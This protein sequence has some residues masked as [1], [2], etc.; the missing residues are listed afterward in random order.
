MK[1]Y[2]IRRVLLL[3]VTLFAII[4]INFVILNLAPGDP[5]AAAQVSVTGEAT[6][7]ADSAAV[8]GENQY[9][10]FREH[11]GLTLPLILNRWPFIKAIEV[12]KGLEKLTLAK[13]DMGVHAYH[14]LRTL[15]G[16]RARFVLPHLIQEAENKSNSFEIRKNAANLFIRGG[17][18]QGDVGVTLTPEQRAKNRAISQNNRFL[19][20]ARILETDELSEL[21]DKVAQLSLWFQEAGGPQAYT[22][23]GSA[24]WH[25]FLLKPGFVVT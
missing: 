25:A 6:R 12:K 16:D 3:P 15:W 2:I 24:K 5:T 19:S 20:G 22:W 13:D 14:T 9:L 23:Q 11:Y 17:V 8:T 10:L 1:A 18:R 21:E 4:L 7:S